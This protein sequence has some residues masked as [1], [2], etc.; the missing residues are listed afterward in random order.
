M[1]FRCSGFLGEIFRT[2]KKKYITFV[3]NIIVM[4]IAFPIY[5]TIVKC[6]MAD[7]VCSMFIVCFLA[8]KSASQALTGYEYVR[9]RIIFL[10][11][12]A[13]NACDCLR[14]NGCSCLSLYFAAS[15]NGR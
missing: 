6:L 14:R 7:T 8:G 13:D 12:S 11:Y 15:F 5:D 9:R 10:I 2:S 1:S 4:I 3:K